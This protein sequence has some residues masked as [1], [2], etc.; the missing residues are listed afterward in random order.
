M[1][2]SQTN[3]IQFTEISLRYDVMFEREINVTVSNDV[4]EN[5][6]WH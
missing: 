2:L 4:I 6:L 5:P 3:K 1:I